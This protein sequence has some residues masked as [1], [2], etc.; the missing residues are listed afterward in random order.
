MRDKGLGFAREP[1]VEAELVGE[2]FRC[3]P[4]A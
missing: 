1:E 4:R 3:E 2:L